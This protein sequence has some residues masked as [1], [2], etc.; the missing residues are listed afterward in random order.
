[1]RSRRAAALLAVA[2]AAGACTASGAEASACGRQ[3]AATISVNGTEPENP[4]VPGNTTEIG[5]VKV[6]A[7]LFTGLVAY[8]P[9]TAAPRNAV[10]ESITA[11]GARVYTIRLRQGWTFHDGTPVT[12]KSFADAWNYTAY[13]PNAQGGAAFLHEIAGF[14]RVNA[15]RPTARKLSGLR[16]LDART[17]RVTLTKPSAVFPLKLGAAAFLPLPKA[18]FAD[19]EAFEARPIGNGPFR[20]VSRRRGGNIVVKRYEKY[21]GAC[22]PRVAGVEFRFYKT[23]DAAYAAVVKNKLDFLEV[24]P[25]SALE[26]NRFVSELPNR[27]M[28]RTALVSQAL[29]FPLYDARFKDPRLRQAISMAIDREGLIDQVFNGLK[30]PSDGYV[31]PMLPGYAKGQ[32]GDLCT[33][34]PERARRMF[35]ASGFTGPIELTSNDDTANQQWMEGACASITRAL[36]RECR[37]LPIPT[38]ADFRRAVNAHEMS[39]IYRSGWVADYPSIENFL[40]PMYRTGGSGNGGLYSN[41]AVD[42]LLDRAAAARSEK[43]RNAL[44]RKAERLVLQDMPAIPLWFQTVQSGWSTR[45]RNVVVTPLRELDLL[46]VSVAQRRAAAR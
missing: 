32:C 19:R 31:P 40:T 20:F 25:A 46:R 9:R 39:A 27:H 23:L 44:Y 29:T 16:L 6:I 10:A 30:K 14:D 36:G 33:Y 42:R 41:R 37:F 35:E 1:M 8:D 22:K 21:G 17:L 28:S 13:G 43:R 7:A 5:G 11:R 26:G 34:Q 2:L 12:A 38:L 15:P 3:G 18:F 24:A 4:L 45:L